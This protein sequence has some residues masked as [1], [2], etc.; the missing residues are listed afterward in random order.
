M[1]SYLHNIQHR[2]YTKFHNGD[3]YTEIKF[4]I[5]SK[6]K[7]EAIQVELGRSDEEICEMEKTKRL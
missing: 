5:I 2:N 1:F 3:Y 7:I 6:K 4:H